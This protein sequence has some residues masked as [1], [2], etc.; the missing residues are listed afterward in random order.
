MKEEIEKDKSNVINEN[1]N[2][3]DGLRKNIRKV[4]R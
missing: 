4:I 2:P 3:F 1:E